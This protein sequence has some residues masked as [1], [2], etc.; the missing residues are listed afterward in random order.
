MPTGSD[1]VEISGPSLARYEE[2][3]SPKALGCSAA[4]P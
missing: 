1:G 4:A 2:I 3:L